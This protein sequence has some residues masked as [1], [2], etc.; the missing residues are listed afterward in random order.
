MKKN[1]F[2][3]QKILNTLI[4]MLNMIMTI[5]DQQITAILTMIKIFNINFLMPFMLN[6]GNT[7]QLQYKS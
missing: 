6:N 3:Q 4:N 1:L 7:V 2:K 5:I